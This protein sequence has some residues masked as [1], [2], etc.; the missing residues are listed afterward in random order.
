MFAEPYEERIIEAANIS[1]E[2]CNKL[3]ILMAEEWSQIK[4]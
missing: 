1:E 2:N 4:T 3:E